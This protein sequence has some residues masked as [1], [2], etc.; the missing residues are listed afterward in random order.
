MLMLQS[1][2]LG[3]MYAY[4]DYGF[5]SFDVYAI[6]VLIFE[7]KKQLDLQKNV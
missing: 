7:D 6:K 5:H 3:S 2:N 4:A 1:C